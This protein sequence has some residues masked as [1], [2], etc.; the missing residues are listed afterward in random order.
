MCLGRSA[1]DITIIYGKPN[2]TLNVYSIT[3]YGIHQP[4]IHDISYNKF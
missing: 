1:S 3:F 4:T 2:D